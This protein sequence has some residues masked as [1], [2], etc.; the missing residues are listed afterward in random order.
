MS[1]RGPCFYFAFVLFTSSPIRASTAWQ[2]LSD[3]QRFHELERGLLSSATRP[4]TAPTR[5]LVRKRVSVS[6]LFKQLAAS[7]SACCALRIS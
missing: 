4:Y 1:R 2:L 7:A 3:P 5:W 6:E